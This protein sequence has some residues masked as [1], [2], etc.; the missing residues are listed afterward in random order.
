[1]QVWRHLQRRLQ[2]SRWEQQVGDN[3][4]F[5]SSSSASSLQISGFAK[6]QT[7]T[8]IFY[9]PVSDD[10]SDDVSV[11]NVT[12]MESGSCSHTLPTNSLRYQDKNVM[13]WH[14]NSDSSPASAG[15][16]GKPAPL[17]KPNKALK[18]KQQQQLVGR[19]AAIESR[20]QNAGLVMCK[21][22]T[23][24]PPSSCRESPQETTKPLPPVC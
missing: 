21:T 15:A 9:L 16:I 2:R 4:T 7:S 14:V 20:N 17:P 6:Q 22:A 18:P 10:D 8:S 11:I 3:L 24:Y 19:S 5:L 13:N 1:M 23:L 12:E